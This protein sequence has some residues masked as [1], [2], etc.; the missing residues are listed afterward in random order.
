[1]NILKSLRWRLCIQFGKYLEE[2]ELIK[3]TTVARKE[4]EVAQFNA[5]K[6]SEEKKKKIL[7]AQG[8]QE[9][10]RIADGLSAREKYE[11]DA[12]V[13]RDIGVAEHMSK[14]VGPQIVTTGGGD[15]KGGGVENALMIQMMQ[16]LIAKK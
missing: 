5:K 16:N 8:I 7:V 10:L 3:A 11:I 13:R 9:E 14:W 1:M 15:G 2:V 12:N 4:Y 6:A